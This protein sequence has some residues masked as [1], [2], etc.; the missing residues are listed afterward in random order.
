MAKTCMILTD[1]LGNQKVV[2]S[3]VF[4]FSM[5]VFHSGSPR[6]VIILSMTWI[7]LVITEPDKH[8]WNISRR[9]WS[10][11]HSSQKL[12]EIGI[13]AAYQVPR[14]IL[15]RQNEKAKTEFGTI[16]TYKDSHDIDKIG[17]VLN[18]VG[19]DETLL[20]RA[21]EISA[22][23]DIKQEALKR[24]INIQTNTVVHLDYFEKN[25]LAKKE[26]KELDELSFLV[27]IVDQDTSINK[28][29]FEVIKEDDLSEGRLVEVSIQGKPVYYQIIEG[30]TKEDVV[31]QKN[32]YGFARATA[33]KVGAWND[34]AHKFETVNWLP[35]INSP[36]FLKQVE[37]P[38][39]N[40]DAIGYFP[41]T[42]YY[43]QIKNI[44]DLITHNTAILGILGIGKSFLTLELVE[45]IITEKIKVIII[46]ITNEYN[47]RL[48]CFYDEEIDKEFF[49]EVMEIG[50]G[51][52]TKVSKNV[53]EGGAILSF[54]ELIYN[55]LKGFLDS[56][57]PYMI[58]IYNPAEFEVWRQDSKPYKD[59]A[60]MASLSPTEI[61]QYIS[62]AAL[63]IV[64]PHGITDKAR[65]C[66]IYEEAHSLVPEFSALVSDG[67]KGATNGTARAILQGRKFGLGCILVTQR[68]ANVT[69][70][71][72]NQCNTIFAMRTFDDTGKTFLANYIGNDYTNRLSTLEAQQAI[73]YGKAS[74]CENPVLLQL[75]DR[76]IFIEKFRESFPPPELP[77]RAEEPEIEDI[78]PSPIAE[79]ET[80]I[81]TEM[82]DDDLPF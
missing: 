3:T 61:T 31:A 43:A 79:A 47:K 45:R 37:K 46:D 78:T 41:R 23:D 15:I 29:E 55:D 24:N 67:D 72:L 48:D 16:L 66:L 10:I 57:N 75:N 56:K 62:E 50:R 68:T 2:F 6:E 60:S 77:Q 44:H 58:K 13:I 39:L 69:K 63:K 82:E 42:S 65:V 7:L 80:Q 59:E 34:K 9:I 14:I 70:T 74:N 21:I 30:I 19:R 26:I 20:L 17:I 27:G 4:I 28:L 38:I 64:Q 8:V 71:I 25:P 35:Q 81:Q 32:K 5:V 40:V 49:K 53:E 51:G 52:K 1:I 76:D 12:R 11:W 54:K 22:P 18:Y 33:L 36:V 73:F